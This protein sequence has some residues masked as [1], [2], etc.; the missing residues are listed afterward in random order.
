MAKA[1]GGFVLSVSSKRT[2]V[3]APLL[4]T[5]VYLVSLIDEFPGN[6]HKHTIF[7]TEILHTLKHRGG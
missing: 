4:P 1:E 3:D 2:V 6:E 7:P 5:V